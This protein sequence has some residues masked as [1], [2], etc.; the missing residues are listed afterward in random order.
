MTWFSHLDRLEHDGIP[1]YI[2]PEKPDWFV[3]SSR[4]DKLLQS[5]MKQSSSASAAEKICLSQNEN[6]HK[7]SLDL[8]RLQNLL[9]PTQPTAYKGRHKHLRLNSLKEIW[10]HLTDKCNLSCRHCLF[11]ASPSKG[12]TIGNDSLEKTISQATELGCHLFYFTG[13]EPFVYPNF[14]NILNLVQNA[15]QASHVVILT[16]GLLLKENIQELIQLDIKRL[17]L[18]ISLDGLQPEHDYLRGRGSYK[19]LKSNLLIAKNSNL[20]VTLSIAV[21]NTNVNDLPAIARQ[22]KQLGASGLHLMYHFVHGKGTSSQFVPP[23]KLFTKIIE[24]KIVCDELDLQIDNFETMK[25][26]VFSMPGTKHDLSNMAWDSVAVG[27]DKCIYPSPALIGIPELNCGDITTGLKT[28]WL[29]SP[30]LNKIRKTSL[31]DSEQS[32][33]NPLRF[34]TGANDPDHSYISGKTFTG[35]DP[36]ATLYDHLA[37]H[38]ISN[39]AKKYPDQGLFRLRMGDFRCDCLDHDDSNQDAQVK[40]THCNCVVSLAGNDG[41]SSVKEFYGSAAKQ[42]NQDIVNPF[43]PERQST[44]FIPENSRNRSYGCGSP[45]QDAKLQSGE[46]IIDLGSGSGVECFLAAEKVGSKGKVFGIDMTDDMLYLANSSKESVVQKLT[47]DNV[48]FKKGYLEE[49]PL[50]DEAANVVIS[51]CVINLSPDKRKTY[52]EIFRVLKPGGRMIISDVVTD[53]MPEIS[54]KNSAKYRGECLGGAMRQNDLISMIEDCGFTSPFFLKRYPYRTIEENEFFSLTYEA[55]KPIPT[56]I[57]DTVARVLYRGPH[58]AIITKSGTILTPGVIKT[59]ST[60][61]AASLSEQ[62]FQINDK[63]TVTNIEQTPCNCTTSPTPLPLQPQTLKHKTDLNNYKNGCMDCGAEL[64]YSKQFTMRTCHFCKTTEKSNSVCKN[65][66]FICDTCHCK[67][68]IE[69]ITHACCSNQ[70]K[71]LIE[72]LDTIRKHPGMPMHGPEHHALIPAVILTVYKNSGGNLSESNIKTG[73]DRAVDIPGGACGFWGNCGAAI[74]AGIAASIILEATPITPTK[75][76]MAQSFS[77]KILTAIAS[78]KGSRC[79]QRETW[80]TL[81]KT[82][83]LSNTYFGLQLKASH[84][85]QCNQYLSNKECIK[86]NCPLWTNRDKK[87]ERSFFSLAN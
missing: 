66:H 69:I 25:S 59:V 43:G 20:A 39:Q 55:R 36:Y 8:S 21:N 76:Q 85:L 37:L 64:I 47:F 63:G 67:K 70:S 9:T 54:I 50:P 58:Q 53:I 41:Y 10:F 15:N 22:A 29:E 18:Q 33:Q 11:S 6:L 52:L 81:K 44:G 75:R 7:S 19:T 49:I 23:K 12:A 46:T 74:G 28:L 31:I 3:P 35:N 5:L 16:N 62:V 80:L 13:G 51:N 86:S 24:T 82:A 73:I 26:Q 79:C 68:G 56:G 60:E 65:N 45:V 40:L 87:Q 57:F 71:D 14:I 34:L 84:S 27:P 42:A 30:V 78:I 83:E 77:A 1:I 61:E 32:N 48:E 2:D 17:H 4:T 72:L 38:V